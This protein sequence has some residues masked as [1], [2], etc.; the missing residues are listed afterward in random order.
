MRLAV[1]TAIYPSVMRYI[2][3]FFNSLDAQ[4]DQSFDLWVGVDGVDEKTIFS[5]LGK[6]I[7]AKFVPVPFRATPAVVRNKVLEQA[8]QKCDAVAL[9]DADD[10]LD[11]SRVEA[12]KK[13][14]GEWDVT[15]TAMKYINNEGKAVAGFFDPGLGDSSL[16]KNNVFGF[17][18]TT[19][20]AQV[21][22]SFLPVP[23]NCVLMDW[24]ISTLALYSGASFGYDEECRMLYRQHHGNIAASRAPFSPAQI[25]KATALVI[26]HYDL[27]LN[28]FAER[29]LEQINKFSEARDYVKQFSKAISDQNVLAQYVAALNLLS[30]KHVWWSCVAQPELEDLWK[31]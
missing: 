30:N 25:T 20:R 26:G 27:V 12:A 24:F 31:Q 16:V 4:T 23:A 22:A 29:R 19:W 18:N 10:I 7:S 15:A 14:A 9:V 28:A 17:S 2:E 11:K 1:V 5:T 13:S 8:L 21:L 3:D 6:N